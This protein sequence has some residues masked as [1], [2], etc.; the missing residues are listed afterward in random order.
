MEGVLK[1]LRIR[2]LQSWAHKAII[3]KIMMILFV[4]WVCY[5]VFVNPNDDEH[6]FSDNL[7]NRNFDFAKLPWAYAFQLY[8]RDIRGKH[9]T[10]LPRIRVPFQPNG[11][12]PVDPFQNSANFKISRS[13]NVSWTLI[14]LF[15]AFALAIF[16]MHQ[17]YARKSKI[18]KTFVEYF[19][20]GK[21]AFDEL[22]LEK[23][24]ELKL[25]IEH[26][27]Q[28]L[29][30]GHFLL[31][32]VSG[33]ITV[34]DAKTDKIVAKSSAK[35][36][37][38]LPYHVPESVGFNINLETSKFSPRRQSFELPDNSFITNDETIWSVGIHKNTIIL[39]LSS[40]NAKILEISKNTSDKAPQV[41][42]K[43]SYLLDRS[44]VSFIITRDDEK[45]FI[46]ISIEGSMRKFSIEPHFHAL[47]VQHGTPGVTVVR[48]MGERIVTGS[49]NGTV[50]VLNE[51]CKTDHVCNGHNYPITALN[52][53]KNGKSSSDITAMSADQSGE[54]RIWTL[55]S[56]RCQ[57][58]LGNY[59]GMI[60]NVWPLKD[61]LVAMTQSGR[62]LIWTHRSGHFKQSF[63]VGDSSNG[64]GI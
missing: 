41:L 5:R 63:K 35:P 8:S 43:F 14:L 36:A 34:Y 56:G 52:L 60:S 2:L 30:T 46:A 11:S 49:L 59:A 4:S 6:Y 19:G 1:P 45:A 39:G 42:L 3:Q 24:V 58:V 21:S 32:D 18:N 54:V 47:E 38:F 20:S 44:G 37:Q 53:F 28:D 10:F 31:V 51:D 12:R 16:K 33:S 13:F 62:V 29:K 40:G 22:K 23:R 7:G 64:G 15:V 48:S 9:L 27:A 17:A 26:I 25:T 55:L 61:I 57:F 50:T